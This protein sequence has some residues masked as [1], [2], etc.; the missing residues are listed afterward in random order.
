M[1]YFLSA[2]PWIVGEFMYLEGGRNMNFYVSVDVI[3]V[4]RFLYP[5]G[6]IKRFHIP[7]DTIIGTVAA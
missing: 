6:Y 1:I 7:G 3:S 5:N 2:S 4:V